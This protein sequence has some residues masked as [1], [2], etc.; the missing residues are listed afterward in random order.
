MFDERKGHWDNVYASKGYAEVSWYQENPV[1]SLAL[2]EATGIG[3][4]EPIID[5]GGGAS[6]LVDKLVE[7]GFS[8][9]TVLDI[10]AGALEQARRRLGPGSAT[11]NWLV[12]DVTGFEADR[13]FRVWH[14]RAV[15]H[16]LV[17][18]EDRQRYID[19]LMRSLA[20]GGHLILA[21]FGP[22]G[23]LKCSGLEIRRYSIGMQAEML[24]P[25]FELQR[26]ELEVHETPAGASQQ[27]LYSHWIRS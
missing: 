24:G 9:I 13:N 19:V 18:P 16:F 25:G 10:A 12:G 5:V 4:D 14:D 22:E 20:P 17:D 7:R 2:I 8:D 15:L 27:F 21:T 3:A 26:H 23:P 11:V 1:R 6:T